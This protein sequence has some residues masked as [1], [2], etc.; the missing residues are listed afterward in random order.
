MEVSVME[1]FTNS[2]L[3]QNTV[4][5]PDN[6]ATRSWAC[7]DDLENWYNSQIAAKLKIVENQKND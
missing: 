3:S 7:K 6:M 4:I 2:E 5:F 1:G